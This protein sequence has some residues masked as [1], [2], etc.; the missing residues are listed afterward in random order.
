[1]ATPLQ[2]LLEMGQSPWYD[3]IRRGLVRSGGLRA[4]RDRGVRGVTAISKRHWA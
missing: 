4:L 1:M 3:N 2:Q